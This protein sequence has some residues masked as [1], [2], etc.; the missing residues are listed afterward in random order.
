M[1]SGATTALPHQAELTNRHRY[2]VLFSIGL[3]SFIPTLDG[4]IVGM[5]LPELGK[6]LGA[7]VATIEWVTSIYLLVLS[8]LLL[9]FGRLGDMRGH[10]DVFLAG[11]IGFT[12]TSAM[13]GLAPSAPW[14]I[15]FRAIQATA[16]A[17][18][19]ANYPA[20]ITSFFPATERGRALGSMSVMVY[21]ALSVGGPLGGVLTTHFGWRSVFY[22]NVPIGI[23]AICLAQRLI[24]RDRPT[25]KPPRFDVLGAVLFF[26][27]LFSLMLALNQGYDWGWTAGPTL[28]LFSVAALLLAIFIGIERRRPMPMLDLSLFRNM[29]FTGSVFSAMM[30]YSANSSIF[31]ILPFYLISGRGMSPESGGLVLLCL[32][33]IMMLTAPIAGTLSDRLGSRKP[34]V[35]G[36]CAL[37]FGLLLL[38]RIA[39]PIPLWQ[40]AV[41]LSICGL[42]FGAFASPNNSRLLGAAPKNRQGIASGVLAG[43][44]NVG[45]V[46]GIGISG[47]VFTIVMHRTGPNGV[48]EAT[49]MSLKTIAIVAAVAAVTSWLE[50]ELPTERSKS[51]SV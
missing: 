6:S 44:R 22:I 25:S 41:P 14:L 16:A 20:L 18:L 19:Y 38:A 36:M 39:K 33:I 26:L 13:C 17:M 21:F 31:F 2:L 50:P 45:F 3:G 51:A 43:A 49:S 11:F 8:G 37:T 42:G 48:A 7:N 28:A 12:V 46:L 40:V 5:I 47:A 29:V 9:P 23:L 27:G 34:T 15:V 4:S 32:P 35:F 24:P 10:K 1:Q 30:N